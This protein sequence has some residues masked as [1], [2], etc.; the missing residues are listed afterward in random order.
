MQKYKI[1][2]EK[3]DFELIKSQNF[4]DNCSVCMEAPRARA[5]EA[6]NAQGGKNLKIQFPRGLGGT[7]NF[8]SPQILL[9]L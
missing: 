8:F 6:S 7:P 3:F 4:S 2:G 5:H 9:L 1:A